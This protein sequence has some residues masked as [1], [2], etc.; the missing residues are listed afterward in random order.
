MESMTHLIEK[1]QSL[2]NQKNNAYAERNE[3]IAFMT[4]LYDSHLC[5][6]PDSDKEWEDEWRW[7]VCIHSPAGQLTWHVHQTELPK[8]YHLKVE[9]NH[10]DGHTTEE[11]YERIRQINPLQLL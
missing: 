6:H 8:F 2:E 3:L 5:R 4:T 11:K 9:E 10:W 7:I 1:L